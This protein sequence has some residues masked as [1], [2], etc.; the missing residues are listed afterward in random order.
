MRLDAG[1]R[2]PVCRAAFRGSRACSRC[3]ADLA[4]LMALTFRAF[5]Q[6]R[7]ARQR[8]LAGDWERALEL[9]ERAQD[10]HATREG[11]GLLLLARWLAS[12][13]P[14]RAGRSAVL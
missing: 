9:A 6:R 10:Q 3:G 8:L 4:P 2:C 7:R 11:Q 5:Q 13:Q 12:G 1:L 14:G